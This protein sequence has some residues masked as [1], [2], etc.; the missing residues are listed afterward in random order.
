GGL[1]MLA[2][3]AMV[4]G[5]FAGMLLMNWQLALIAV[6]TM[7]LLLF[8]MEFFRSRSRQAYDELRVKAARINAFLQENFAGIEL[9]QLYQRE[10]K[11]YQH[12]KALNKSN[13]QSGLNSAVY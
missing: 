6:G 1:A 2:D 8:L 5:A 3:V 10:G 7:T 4:I 11:N 12:F 9:V 13:L